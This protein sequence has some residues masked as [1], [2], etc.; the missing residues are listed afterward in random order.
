MQLLLEGGYD[1]K[2]RRDDT[3]D[4]DEDV[5]TLGAT[6]EDNLQ[7]RALDENHK[8][9]GKVSGDDSA[10]GGYDDLLIPTRFGTYFTS[11]KALL[12]TISAELEVCG[13]RLSVRELTDLVGVSES[14]IS[15]CLEDLQQA[16]EGGTPIATMIRDVVVLDSYLQMRI[17]ELVLYLHRTNGLR[18]VPQV[19][20][21]WDL[22]LEFTMSLLQ[23][24]LLDA[25]HHVRL[26]TQRNGTKVLV[27]DA[28]LD[29]LETRF[30]GALLAVTARPVSIEQICELH[31]WDE[32]AW[33]RS[34]IVPRLESKTARITLPGEFH[35][36]LY[37]PNSYVDKQKRAA[38]EY[39]LANGCIS[40]EDGQN[41]WGIVASTLKQHLEGCHGDSVVVLSEVL[42]HRDALVTSLEALV[43]EAGSSNGWVDLTPH[44]PSQLLA[45]EEDCR[46]LLEEYVIN[47]DEE[48][49]EG[50]AILTSDMAI[51]V[52]RALAQAAIE[53]TITPLV[54][55]WA[56][57]RAHQLDVVR[58]NENKASIAPPVLHKEP[59]KG[60]RSSS[61][62]SDD[63]RVEDS[64][65]SEAGLPLDQIVDAFRV[66][67]PDL[68]AETNS[69]IVRRL[70]ETA[71]CTDELNRSSIQ[72]MCDRALQAEVKRL[73]LERAS[74]VTIRHK[75]SA[76]K[77]QDIQTSFEDP[78]C[79]ATACYMIQG[80]T[81]FLEYAGSVGDDGRAGAWLLSEEALAELRRDFLLGFGSEFTRRLTQYCWFRNEL[82]EAALSFR[83]HSVD[84]MDDAESTLP[85]FCSPV[86]LSA[87][88]FARVCLSCP[89]DDV[90]AD[91]VP[92]GA[93]LDK[94]RSSL[95][96]TVGIALARQWILCGA[97]SHQG[98]T[99]AGSMEGFLSH[100][101]ENCLTI[102]GLPFKR[103]DKKAKKQFLNSR[104]QQLVQA[105]EAEIDP[106]ACLEYAVM[107][108]VQ[109]V[110]NHVVFGS[111][112]RGSVLLLLTKEK[113]IS[114]EVSGALLK[115]AE[116]VAG[117]G[118]VDPDLVE[119]VKSHAL[120]KK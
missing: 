65:P 4:D 48:G 98:G 111:H 24:R 18:T 79:F 63:D 61:K 57:I 30:Y 80:F 95:P 51:F 36:N 46:K 97:E 107:L 47:G 72:S 66:Q 115:L 42:V 67:H 25:S 20:N 62:K 88:Q 68:S 70:C 49:T 96:P 17:D 108:L 53:S 71:F 64:M 82:E 110:K 13:G 21:E 93:P 8:K 86:S 1:F 105:L 43:Q 31:H 15:P 28:Y 23:S 19:S 106:V 77:T 85:H 11:R 6:A 45:I 16:P 92:K 7:A 5:A 120:G 56:K 44:V 27:T 41:R 14:V 100:V 113:K 2:A 12:N 103:L 73:A 81:S 117:G 58:A 101:E 112:L 40:F 50:W 83:D 114:E 60:K 32:P 109:L 99:K 39:F 89:S 3:D 84:D 76:F 9:H 38:S 10:S 90:N 26:L 75:D 118:D 54:E 91:G 94:L 78:S 74:K 37:V 102:C 69:A 52:S 116:Q 34:M 119:Q 33:I 87:R 35:G 59:K 104:R 55:P 22:P 29:Q